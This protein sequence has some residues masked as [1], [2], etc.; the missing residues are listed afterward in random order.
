MAQTKRGRVA[1]VG[2]GIAGIS[3]AHRLEPHFEVTLFEAESVLGGHAH[4]VGVQTDEGLRWLDT[5]F[6]IF[7]DQTY[8]RFT[9]FLKQLGVL[10]RA[11][12]AEMSSCFSDPRSDFHFALGLGLRPFLRQW[13]TLNN[14]RMYQIMF[15]FLRFRRRALKDVNRPQRLQHVSCGEYL[16]RYSNA[17]VNNFILPLTASIWSLPSEYIRQ[18]PISSL[19]RYFHNHG[20]LDGTSGRRWLSFPDSSRTYVNAFEA[21]FAGKIRRATTIKTIQRDQDGIELHGSDFTERFDH[22]V[23]ATHA[24]RALKLLAAPTPVEQK[25]LG[26]WRYQSNDVVLHSDSEV[27]HADPC[28][29]S[30]WNTRLVDGNYE[31][32][33]NLNR[34]Q[35]LQTTAPYIV[36]LGAAARSEFRNV[37]CRRNYMHPIFDLNALDAQKDLPSLNG[38][39]RTYYCGS[40]FGYGFHEDA[41]GAGADA[42]E[43][44]LRAAP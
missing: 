24:D 18:H 7:N 5:G 26:V 30:S 10:D 14:R 16:E 8:P 38:I 19:L 37:H 11:R 41:F 40:Y 29:W 22:V 31:I 35:G 21:Q 12:P 4:G 32:S 44:L 6:L 43:A 28:L 17:F 36:T 2:G 20:L 39:K 34:I 15:D 9:N 42:G 13:R 33:Y 25:V 23:I 27:L 1:V 3:A